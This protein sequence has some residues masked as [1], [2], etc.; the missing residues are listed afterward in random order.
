MTRLVQLARGTDRRIALV[1]E[2]SLRCLT[3]VDSVYA[4]ASDAMRDGTS[5]VA[6]AAERATGETLDYDAVYAGRSEWRLLPPIDHPTDPARC[7]VSGTGITHLGSARD[8]DA[9]HEAATHARGVEET[10]SMRM[11]RWGLEGG[12]PA[13]D[14]IGIAPEWFYKGTGASVRAHGEAVVQPPHAEDGGEEAEVAGCYVVGPDGTPWRVGM[15]AGNEFADH[16]FERRNYLN[17]AG[18]KLRE[19]ALG[20]ELVVDASFRSVA[21]T[22]AIERDG[23]TRWSKA[24]LTGEDEM[25]HSLRNLEHHHFKFD[26]HRRPGDVHV[27]FFG[28]CALS[29]GEGIALADGDEM[30]VHFDGFGRPLR[31]VL[32]VASMPNALITARS[33]A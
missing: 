9:M 16:R 5:L 25:S 32:R 18:S 17:L 28:A 19:C 10:D 11:F 26:A 30:V 15:C 8:R 12:K 3:G 20:P 6:R 4:L 2:P 7:L 14:A 13:S 1:D 27:H 24:I 33:L 21:G 29:F 23:V 22:V 31:N